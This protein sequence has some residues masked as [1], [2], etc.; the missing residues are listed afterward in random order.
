[1]LAVTAARTDHTHPLSGLEIGPR[2]DPTPRPAGR[3]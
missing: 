2:P 3:S 1:M